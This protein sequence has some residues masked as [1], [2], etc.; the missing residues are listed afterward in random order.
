MRYVSAGFSLHC[1]AGFVSNGELNF[2]RSKGY[3]Q[4]LSVLR[5][6]TEVRNMCSKLRLN[7]LLGMLSPKGTVVCILVYNN[8]Q[9]TCR[10][11]WCLICILMLTLHYHNSAA[12]WY[13]DY[14]ASK[15]C[16]T[17]GGTQRDYGVEGTRSY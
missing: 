13:C 4:P 8:V 11:M 12:R 15:S 1:S 16:Y 14:G 17:C 9:C 3:I 7:V 2:L 5:I 10:C 6:H